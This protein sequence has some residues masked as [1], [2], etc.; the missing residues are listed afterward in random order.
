MA[1]ILSQSLNRSSFSESENEELNTRPRK[2]GVIVA[3]E[4]DTRPRKD[5]VIVAGELNTRPRKDGVIVAGE[6]PESD[7]D[8]LF[9]D[10]TDKTPPTPTLSMSPKRISGQRTGTNE[11]QSL[12]HRRLRER[13]ERLHKELVSLTRIPYRESIRMVE[14]SSTCA[15]K[16]RRILAD[17]SDQLKRLRDDVYLLRVAF[18][19]LLINSSSLPR[20]KT[21]QD[22]RGNGTVANQGG[23]LATVDGTS[24]IDRRSSVDEDLKQ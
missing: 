6:V 4:V 15:S 2:D 1:H 21:S 11:Y 10:A 12:L 17:S 24:S 20:F 8:E 7:E 19:R 23:R 16:S 3:G 5:G 13:N 22:E 14:E 18:D 9:E